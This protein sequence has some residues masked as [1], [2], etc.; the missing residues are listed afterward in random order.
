MDKEKSD[1]EREEKW[2]LDVKINKK[3]GRVG[4]K[5]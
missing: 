4:K 3:I 1:E 2:R 5:K